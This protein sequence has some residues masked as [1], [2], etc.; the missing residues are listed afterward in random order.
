MGDL[1]EGLFDEIRQRMVTFCIQD[2]LVEGKVVP[3]EAKRVILPTLFLRKI[4]SVVI[5]IRCIDLVSEMF[6]PTNQF[7]NISF[8]KN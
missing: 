6:A 8:L 4:Y 5:E 7:E 3:Q 2:L 1:S